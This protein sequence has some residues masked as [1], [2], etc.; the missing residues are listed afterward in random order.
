MIAT[1]GGCPVQA[2]NKN[3]EYKSSVESKS[4]PHPV[5]RHLLPERDKFFKLHITYHDHK[6][7]SIFKFVNQ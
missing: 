3:R 1:G 6:M 5:H 4:K 7:N 2:Y